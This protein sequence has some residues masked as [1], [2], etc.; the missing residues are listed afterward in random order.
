MSEDHIG[1][2]WSR[3]D[4]QKLLAEI[5]INIPEGHT[6][7]TYQKTLKTM[8]WNKVAFPPYTPE[9]CK[10]KWGN[11][12]QKMRKF[13]SLPELLVEAEDVLSNPGKN[14]GGEEDIEVSKG[15]P[16]KPLAFRSAYNLFCNDQMASMVGLPR[17]TCITTLAK[18]WRELPEE[19]KK[20][21]IMCYAKL[22]KNY[23]KELSDYLE[24]LSPKERKRI[25][26]E[27]GLKRPKRH[28][29]VEDS[30]GAE[31]LPPKPPVNSFSV[32]LKEQTAIQH[33]SA[34]TCVKEWVRRWR[35]LTDEQRSEYTRRYK[36]MQA[37]YKIE[38]NKYLETLDEEEQKRVLYDN[39]IKTSKKR[40]CVKRLPG[41]PK[42]PPRS[43]HAVYCQV[44]MELLKNEFTVTKERFTK[45]NQKWQELSTVE[46]EQYQTK[47][48]RNFKEY[49]LTAEQQES[50]RM[51]NPKKCQYLNS[52]KT[53]F[54]VS[55]EHLS[56][57]PSDSEDE[58]LDS[59]SDEEQFTVDSDEEEEEEEEECD[60]AFEID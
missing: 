57:S 29:I 45:V 17:K 26:A 4:Q 7:C 19:Q 14:D 13:R 44:Q 46:K 5:K 12:L 55:S 40:T 43:G 22:K 18:R 36:A 27:C 8:D 9:E 15:L 23:K 20:D 24:F 51:R 30:E 59:S 50:Y 11:M 38:L 41:E 54:H 28:E 10:E 58:D 25:R 2:G 37:K 53:N 6:K 60:N 3:K 52:Q 42:S 1:S 34:K 32:F 31:G 16:P 49:T 33:M 48:Q 47:L 21:Y 56:K 35:D 39:G